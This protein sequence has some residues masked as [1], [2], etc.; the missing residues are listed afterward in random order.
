[1][2]DKKLASIVHQ[3]YYFGESDSYLGSDSQMY[4]ISYMKYQLKGFIDEYR[5]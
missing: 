1:M 5:E 3:V 2:T 4:K